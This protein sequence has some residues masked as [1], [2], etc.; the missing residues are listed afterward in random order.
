MEHYFFGD[1][2]A[3]LRG[4]P[5]E[6]GTTSS[7]SGFAGATFPKGEGFWVTGTAFGGRRIAAPTG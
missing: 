4:R 3:T 7:V 5:P 6:R 2:G 1:V